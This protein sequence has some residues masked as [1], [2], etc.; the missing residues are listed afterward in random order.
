MIMERIFPATKRWLPGQLL[1]DV[2]KW[3]VAGSSLSR[4]LILSVLYLALFG[5]LATYTFVRRDVTA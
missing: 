4:S 3:G 2:G 5:A 1:T